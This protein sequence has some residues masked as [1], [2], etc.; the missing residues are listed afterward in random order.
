VSCIARVSSTPIAAL[1]AAGQS[2]RAAACAAQRLARQRA[3][4]QPACV[5]SQKSA[6]NSPTIMPGDHRL[7]DGV[8]TEAI[9]A[10]QIPAGRLAGGVQPG[11]V[12]RGA[13]MVCANPAHGVVLRRP[14]GNQRLRRVDPRKVLADL[15][16]L[17]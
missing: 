13:A 17:A 9:E 14:H 7:G 8:A 1:A 5:V 3:D 6:M 15:L 16:D 2:A 4:P 11:I 12:L 10:V